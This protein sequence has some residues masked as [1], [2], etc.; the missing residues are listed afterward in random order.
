MNFGQWNI[1]DASACLTTKMPMC[2]HHTV[3]PGIFLIDVNLHRR[4][5]LNKKFQ[6]VIHRC[7]RQCGN[8]RQQL[9][10]NLIH[11]RMGMM[12]KQI[13]HNSYA[14]NRGLNAMRQ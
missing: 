2:F 6:R 7:F 10:I 12:L 3:E 14:L 4:S 1:D 9:R 5:L 11:G 13:F 8:L